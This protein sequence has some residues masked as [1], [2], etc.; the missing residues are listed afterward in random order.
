MPSAASAKLTGLV[1]ASSFFAVDSAG[2]IGQAVTRQTFKPFK[3]VCLELTE[4]RCH[5][6]S[7]GM[8][9]VQTERIGKI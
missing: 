4:L 1:R 6:D 8:N 2:A 5:D 3:R 9:P 7:F